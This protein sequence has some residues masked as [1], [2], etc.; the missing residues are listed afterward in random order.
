MPGERLV[1]L[2]TNILLTVAGIL[3]LAV[4]VVG[5]IIKLDESF[6]ASGTFMRYSADSVRVDFSVNATDA[7]R[8]KQGQTV[9]VTLDGVAG[10]T[11][12]PLTTPVE[13]VLPSG[14]STNASPYTMVVHLPLGEF[15]SHFGEAHSGRVRA[16][17]G[18]GKKR[19][20]AVV[21]RSLLERRGLTGGLP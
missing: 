13:A 7:H 1:D 4:I 10:K 17:I 20:A 15:T 8:V 3:L 21:V 19:A 11:N 16:T 18:L 2:L 9:A 14:K 12:A 5:S 6:V